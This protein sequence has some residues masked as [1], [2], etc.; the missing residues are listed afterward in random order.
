MTYF[1]SSRPTLGGSQV[2]TLQYADAW[3]SEGE[4]VRVVGSSLVDNP[5]LE[6]A[7]DQGFNVGVI[8]PPGLFKEFGKRYRDYGRVDLASK[9]I[10]TPLYYIRQALKLRAEGV[11]AVCVSTSR[12]VLQLGPAVRLAGLPLIYLAQGGLVAGGRLTRKA[13]V[14]LPSAVTCV[15]DAVRENI[16]YNGRKDDKINV[17]M[18]G[19]QDIENLVPDMNK[20][21]ILFAGNV[22]PE[23]G[24]HHLVTAYG[25]L[26]SE[27]KS[28]VRLRIAG[29]SWDRE[30]DTYLRQLA[31]SENVEFLGFRNDVPS[32][33]QG[34]L[35][36]VA[37]SVEE[38]TVYYGGK[39]HRVIWK[40]GFCLSA[41]EG[42]RG[43]APVVASNSYGLKEVVE[44]GETGL[45]VEPSSVESLTRAIQ[46]LIDHPDR[47][48]SM[49]E[50]GRRRFLDRF[51]ADRMQ[52]EFVDFMRSVL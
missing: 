38:E 51:T 34:A 47:A 48:R 2:I 40:E 25:H 44:S 15:S 39:S 36:L 7:A 32:L 30:Y 46:D 13:I 43:G 50:A 3:R 11:K 27:L 21:Y 22:V 37:P 6:K 20:N 18:N 16:I 33:M 12:C 10:A 31:G 17:I 41:L 45:L 4:T 8:K 35:M 23:K 19:I 29:K 26:D 52:N 49:G 14:T 24:V 42:M 1:Y 9:V 5:F 28:R